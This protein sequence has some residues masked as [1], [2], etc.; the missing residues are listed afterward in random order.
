[1][2]QPDARIGSLRTATSNR[3]VF[4]ASR[5]D[6]Y[7][8]A[9]RAYVWGSPPVEMARIRLRATNP[10]DP[11]APRSP[12]STGAPLNRWGHQTVP[13]DPTSRFGVGPS[14]DLLYSSLRL[15]L[16]EGP[17]VVEVP[18]CGTRYY[19]VQIAFADS[20]A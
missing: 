7:A 2:H 9:V 19:T 14:V 4:D 1:M 13:A 3:E 17:F 12:A 10:D 5:R 15:D 6:A 11:H 18:D 20:S 8:V 16:A